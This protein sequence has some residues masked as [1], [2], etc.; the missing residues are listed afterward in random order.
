MYLPPN[1]LNSRLYPQFRKPLLQ[2]RRLDRRLQEKEFNNIAF[3]VRNNG[4]LA[5][6]EPTVNTYAK[7]ITILHRAQLYAS[8]GPRDCFQ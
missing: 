5:G 4:L 8:V 6:K 1:A 3:R 2:L 7:Q